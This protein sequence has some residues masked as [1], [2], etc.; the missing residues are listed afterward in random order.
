[1]SRRLTTVAAYDDPVRAQVA[2]NLLEEAGVSAVI[3][4][5]EIVAM[6]WL[7]SNAV[8]GIK[9]QVWEEDAERAAAVLDEKFNGEAGLASDSVDEEELARQ[10]LAE[11]P[12]DEPEG[13]PPPVDGRTGPEP[14]DPDEPPPVDREKY[15]WRAFVIAWW[16]L[17]VW[18]LAFY[19]LY[20]FLNAAFGSGPLSRLGRV[21][22]GTSG[23]ILA[24][25][26]T[27]CAV[28]IWACSGGSH[29]LTP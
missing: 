4:D 18:P 23:F 3:T 6:D 12:D 15:A 17:A 19:A 25:S 29:P 10:A 24:C 9:V 7:L 1:M 22:L 28:M 5:S 21:R 13:D 14:P 26:L 8:G 16:G 11:V 27:M 2:R 20:L